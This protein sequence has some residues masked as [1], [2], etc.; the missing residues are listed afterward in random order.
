[1]ETTKA[2]L[3]IVEVKDVSVRFKTVDALRQISF[4][5]DRGHIWGLAGSDGAGKSTLLRLI[6]T[7]IKP[8]QGKIFVGG[9]NVV[10]QKNSIKHLIGYMPQRFGLYTDLTVEEN[11]DF[12]MDI[13]EVPRDQ[14]SNRKSGI[15]DF[16]ICFLLWT[17]LPA[18]FPVE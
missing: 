15:W 17:V 11:I 12:F 10:T 8:T 5:V 3:P 16:P 14:R 9:L 13:F 6:A 1:M 7:M 4:S 2:S 18:I